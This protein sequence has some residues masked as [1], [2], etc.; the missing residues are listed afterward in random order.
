MPVNLSAI[1]EIARRRQPPLLKRWLVALCIFIACSGLFTY[2]LCSVQSVDQDIIFWHLFLTLPLM[3]WSLLF[4]FRWL[5][6]LASE[7]VADGWDR[8]R[9]RDIQAQIR[10]GQRYLLLK[11]VSVRLPHIVTSASLSRQFILPQGIALPAVADEHARSVS[12]QASFPDPEGTFSERVIKM[13]ITLLEDRALKAVLAQHSTSEPLTVVIQA[14][15]DDALRCIEHKNIQL[16]ISSYLPVSSRIEISPD[17]NFSHIDRWLDDPG[18]MSALLILSVNLHTKISN[19]EG[20]AAVALLFYRGSA[21][22]HASAS[23]AR[24]HRPEQSK[25]SASFN[26]SANQALQWGKTHAEEITS[27]WVAGMGM[28]HKARMLLTQNNLIFPGINEN[29]QFIDIDIKTGRTGATS[30]WLAVALASDNA[31]QT[32]SPQLI[33]SQAEKDLANWWVIVQPVPDA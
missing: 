22:E 28:E 4:S 1:P 6:Y 26:T 21:A 14:G 3:S 24:L 2:W 17:F 7:S 12:Y 20:E 30:P 19:G 10:R 23:I 13:L 18:A 15:S 31:K 33:V 8:E 16:A 27:L 5:F 32:S 25:D 11:G 9:E 29:S